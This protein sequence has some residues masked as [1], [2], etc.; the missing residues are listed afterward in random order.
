MLNDEHYIYRN[1]HNQEF[2]NWTHPF[3]DKKVPMFSS[4]TNLQKVDTRILENFKKYIEDSPEKR[5]LPSIVEH[6]LCR[7]KS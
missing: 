3:E 2:W 1:L 6:V 5:R 4:P 7:S